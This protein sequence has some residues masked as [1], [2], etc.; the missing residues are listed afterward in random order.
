MERKNFFAPF[1][2]EQLEK[3]YERLGLENQ[4]IFGK[5][6]KDKS[7]CIQ[8]LECLTGN[9]IDDVNEIT[10][11]KFVKICNDAKGV[12]Y[13]VYIEDS[14][15]RIYDAEMQ[16]LNSIT[17][18]ELPLRSRFY[19]GMIDL[20]L[21]ESG[22]D[23]ITLQESYVIFICTS[24]PFDRNLGCYSISNLCHEDISLPFNDKRTILYFNTKGN[25][26]SISE[27]AKNFLNYIESRTVN[28][29]FVKQLDNAVKNARLNKE[30]RVEYMHSVVHDR[31][32][33][34]IGKREGIEKGMIALIRVCR[35]MNISDDVI[36]ENLITEFEINE[37]MAKDLLLK[38]CTT[39]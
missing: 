30:W 4:F 18:E 20:A 19:Q 27:N 14:L 26:D 5:V 16:N 8:M 39:R 36:L 28:G 10:V 3:Q 7:L 37:E 23:Y 32:M 21:L 15:N 2:M 24:D 11:E 17:K 22:T 29:D 33:I 9:T 38:E 31:D 12:R 25:L 13:D 6:M 1:T 35:K 34:N